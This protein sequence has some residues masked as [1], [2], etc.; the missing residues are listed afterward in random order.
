MAK[1]CPLFSSSSGNSVYIGSGAGGILIDTGVSCSRL[2]KALNDIS[3]MPESIRAVFLTHEHSDHVA[4]LD[5]FTGKYGIPVFSSGGT[6]M[7]LNGLRNLTRGQITS[8]INED[9]VEL[10]DMR[11]VPF[12][13]SHDVSEPFGYRIELSDGRAIAVMTDTGYVSSHMLSSVT[14]CDLVYIESNHD[15]D[16]LRTGQYPYVLKQRI[17]SEKGHLSND[18]CADALC[19]LVNKGTTRIVLAHLSEHNNTPSIAYNTSEAALRL[20]GARRG[21]DYLLN[22]ASP[23]NR[24]GVTVF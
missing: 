17:L 8:A 21:A 6:L 13:T 23:E 22:V 19:A 12:R 3:V 10:E 24:E 15:V 11:V 4:G 18:A 5:V 9:G 2:V 14:G 16:M 20:M 1:F 7:S